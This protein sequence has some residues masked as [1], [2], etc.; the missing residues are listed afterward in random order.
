ML[1]YVMLCYVMLCY[2]I[3]DVRRKLLYF[4]NKKLIYF[5][6]L[7]FYENNCIIYF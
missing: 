6:Y 7:Y 3:K 2:V 1:C 4:F 5:V